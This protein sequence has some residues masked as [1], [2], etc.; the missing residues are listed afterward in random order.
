MN[1]VTLKHG[2]NLIVAYYQHIFLFDQTGSIITYGK[3][4]EAVYP[5]SLIFDSN[6][7]GEAAGVLFLLYSTTSTTS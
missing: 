3:T 7:A 1:A 4:T 5:L 6:Y 2:T